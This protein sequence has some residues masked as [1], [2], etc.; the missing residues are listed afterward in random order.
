MPE[1]T[2]A[3]VASYE[4]SHTVSAAVY[5]L[6][7]EGLGELGP[8][9]CE[10]ISDEIVAL[11]CAGHL[12]LALDFSKVEHVHFRRARAM[13]VPRRRLARASGGELAVFGASDYVEQILRAAGCE[14]VPRVATEE[15]AV[16]IVAGNA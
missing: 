14:E 9:A 11:L 6:Q 13:L 12:R 1:I 5:V 3:R 4:E 16:R 15:E 8:E 7:V 10:Q 2:F